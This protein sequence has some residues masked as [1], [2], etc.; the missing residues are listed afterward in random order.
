MNTIQS[1]LLQLADPAGPKVDGELPR[2]E[3]NGKV[4]DLADRQGVLGVVVTNL[5][6]LEQDGHACKGQSELGPRVANIVARRV[7]MCLALRSQ[8][9]EVMAAMRQ[10]GVPT[11]ILKGSDFAD[12]LYDHPSLRWYTDV[13]LLIPEP[14]RVA[15]RQAMNQLGYQI[16]TAGMKYAQGYGEEVWWRDQRS[17]GAVEVHTN[18]VNSP[19][20]R[21]GVSVAFGDLELI[22]NGAALCPSPA[23][24]VLIAAVHG[25]ASHGFDRLQL[26]VD[27]VQ[28]VRRCQGGDEQRLKEMIAG[29]GA[30]LSM[31]M[32]LSLG[33]AL[34]GEEACPQMARRLGL[35]QPRWPARLLLSPS[36]VM[37]G[38][39]RR[40][41]IRRQIFRQMLKRR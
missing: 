3:L 8:A 33:Y 11:V 41:S 4:V 9:A 35:S 31:A 23:A 25:A 29:S 10:V 12:G 24:R 21:R 5:T 13:D 39:A 40:D 22:D 34:L 26:I 15:A 18:L 7:S 38:H 32:G 37:R 19:T 28:A 17:A 16:T 30:G 1:I 20:I 36:V 14:G 2:P 6:R 27:L